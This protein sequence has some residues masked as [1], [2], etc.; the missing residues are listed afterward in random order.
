MIAT[1]DSPLVSGMC[2][3]TRL[4]GPIPNSSDAPCVAR[5]IVRAT[6][7]N[8]SSLRSQASFPFSKSRKLNYAAS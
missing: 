1:G 8:G 4:P 6:V 3:W 5:P 7:L 2:H